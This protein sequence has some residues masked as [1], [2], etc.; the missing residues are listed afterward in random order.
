VGTFC[1]AFGVTKIEA[2]SP[3]KHAKKAV[4]KRFKRSTNPPP[5][6]PP[7][8]NSKPTSS[9]KKKSKKKP[10]VCY[11]CGKPGH[12]AFQCKT[13]QNINELFVDQPELKRS[14]SLS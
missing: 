14:F 11:E 10:I 3:N 5:K 8:F 6:A 1:E 2:P 9:K 7:A 12:K 13:E 4:D